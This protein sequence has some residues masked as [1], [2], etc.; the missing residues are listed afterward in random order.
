MS[1]CFVLLYEI[2][3]MFALLEPV[4]VAAQSIENLVAYVFASS[5]KILASLPPVKMRPS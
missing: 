5:A 4:N 3:L 1:L 2:P